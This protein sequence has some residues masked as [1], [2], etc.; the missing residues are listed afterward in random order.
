MVKGSR[1]SGSALFLAEQAL[2]WPKKKPRSPWN[3][4]ERG[5]M[6]ESTIED[7]QQQ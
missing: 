6:Y 4:N 3:G 2:R 5:H 1:L 7:L